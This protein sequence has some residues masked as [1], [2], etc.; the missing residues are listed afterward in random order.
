MVQAAQVSRAMLKTQITSVEKTRPAPNVQQQPE[1]PT[2][3]SGPAPTVLRLPAALPPRNGA[4]S[5]AR[6]ADVMR[7]PEQ[8]SSAPSRARTM[9]TMQRSVGNARIS[10]MLAVPVQTKLTVGAPGDAHEQEADQV[11]DTV[12]RMAEPPAAGSMDNRP[13]AQPVQR[14]VQRS[15]LAGMIQRSPLSDQLEQTWASTQ[16]KGRI[17]DQLRALSPGASASDPDTRAWLAKTFGQ[18]TDD[19]WLAQTILEHGPEPLWP[20][21]VLAERQRRASE[22]R[23]A[24]ETGAIEASLGLTKGKRQVK[25][26]FFPGISNQRA[27]VIAGVHGTERQGIQVA[28]LLI[29]NLKKTQPFF[30][31]IVVPTLFPDNQ[32]LGRFGTREGA[33]KT[34]R[35]FPVGGMTLAEA[36]KAGGGTP[37]DK[38]KKPILPENM[39][40][41]E[42]ME[43][44]QP[45]RIISIHGTWDASKAGVFSDPHFLSASKRQEIRRAAWQL[46]ADWEMF[47]PPAPTRQEQERRRFAN[48]AMI[49][50]Q[51]IA[52]AEKLN[53][54][55]TLGDQELAIAAAR[56]IAD[57]TKGLTELKKRA[58]G[59]AVTANPAVAGNQLD[60]GPGKENP[61]WPGGTDEGVSL[62]SYAP[63]RGMSVFTVEP[64]IN[65]NIGDY[66]SGED[67]GVSKAQREL[68]LKAYAEVV[69]TLLLGDPAKVTKGP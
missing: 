5:T 17:F 31:V 18:N 68:E 67:P 23:W 60:R 45:S 28:E 6:A 69:E 15:A 11:A 64:A 36:T 4:P 61:T 65:R 39:M 58:G 7:A 41:M 51:L 59:K 48:A 3:Q 53:K 27:L 30:T 24:P 8:P 62:G 37:K 33:T 38:N 57:K 56:S 66:P 2:L 43:R 63:G 47:Q 54:Q 22:H 35:N 9:Q 55:R 34:N 20:G 50:Q 13:G 29:A 40:L 25:A 44:F 19:L 1:A 52:E 46:A 12:M 14:Q 26:F 16:T 10:R 32:A 49:E 42:L 21:E